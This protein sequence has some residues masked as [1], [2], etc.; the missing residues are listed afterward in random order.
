LPPWARWLIQLAPLI[1]PGVQAVLEYIDEL[2]HPDSPTP[3]EWR[4]YVYHFRNP[5]NID[6]ADEAVT[7]FDIVNIT[8]GGIDVSW[9]E[10]DYATVDGQ[11]DALVTGWAT[12]M[13]S[14]FRCVRCAVYRMQFTVLPPSG[15][16][17]ADDKP[18]VRSGPPVR[19]RAL[20]ILGSA[21]AGLPS[22]ISVTATEKTPYAKHWGRNYLP[23]PSQATVALDGHILPAVVDG[24]A[25]NYEAHYGSLQA[26][27]FYP[28]VPVT[29]IDKQPARGLLGVNAVQVDDVFD[30]QRRRRLK[31]ASRITEARGTGELVV[32]HR[33]PQAEQLDAKAA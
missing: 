17:L 16:A 24:I 19:D 7:T 28:V 33:G 9:T 10:G 23:F 22:Q 4:R 20:N 5:S 14:N 1:P 3:D 27:E 11:L 6:E 15:T 25:T 13:G 26:N 18:F 31:N 2:Q 12:N 29:Q 21:N 30:V 8:G 32:R